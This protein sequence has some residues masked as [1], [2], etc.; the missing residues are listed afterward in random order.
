M[1]PKASKTVLQVVSFITVVVLVGAIAWLSFSDPD[2]CANPRGD[3]FAAIMGEQPDDQD[4][5][6]NRALIVKGECESKK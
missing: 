6:V 5:L 1:L 4:A 2:P 3:I